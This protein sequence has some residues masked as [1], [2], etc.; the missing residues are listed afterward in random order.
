MNSSDQLKLVIDNSER[1]LSLQK[2]GA[3]RPKTFRYLRS[4]LEERSVILM[5]Y[6]SAQESL[7]P[8]W[9]TWLQF[10]LWRQDR[11]IQTVENILLKLATK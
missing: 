5:R 6:E 10:Q 7:K 8:V 2:A 9:S 1:E 4:L 3:L 11:E